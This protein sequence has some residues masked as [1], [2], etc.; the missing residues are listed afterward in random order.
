MP[1]AACGNGTV[2]AGEQCETGQLGGQTCATQGFGN[3]AGTSLSCNPATCQFDTSACNPD[4]LCG[5]GSFNYP[6]WELACSPGVLDPVSG[7]RFYS[8]WIPC[9]IIGNRLRINGCLGMESDQ[10]TTTRNLGSVQAGTYQIDFSIVS[11]NSEGVTVGLG[12]GSNCPKKIGV[13]TYSCTLTNPSPFSTIYIFAGCDSTAY[14][15]IDNL[16]LRKIG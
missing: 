1:G 2:E 12:G 10:D 6:D 5:A 3:C 7:W 14:A 15:Y 9:G 8:E 11:G 16:T 13:G 4:I